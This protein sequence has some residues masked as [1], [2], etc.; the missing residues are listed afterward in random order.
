MQHST[1][2]IALKIGATL[3]FGL[4]YVGIKLAGSVPVGEVVLFRAFFALFPLFVLA[5]YTVGIGPMMRTERPLLHIVRSAVG[6][7][8][9]FLNFAALKVLPLADITAFGFVQPIFAVVLAAL[10]LKET[11]GPYRGAAVAIGFAGVMMM[12]EP[13]GGVLGIAAHGFS[14]GAGL[15]LGSALVS[16]FVVIYIRQ[17]SATEKSET[18]VFYFMS[19]C[20]VVGA[21]SLIW[22]RAPLSWG[23]AA[24]LA[25]AGVAGGFGQ[26]GMTFSYRYAE[27]SLLAPFDY[28]AM[29]W[30]VAFGLAIFG[31]VPA[32]LVL[33]GAAVVTAAGVFIA[34][35]EH[36]IGRELAS[37]VEAV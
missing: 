24:W 29:I 26:I 4:Q 34:W 15:A 6:A 10:V 3:A 8:G 12:I 33:I 32:L 19:L 14:A 31:E 25:A 20:T 28:S 21:V 35:R 23:A 27:P 36:R 2:G 17:M 18:I 1:R 16:A 30:A 5:H 7:T 22:W 9:M 13:H 37:R 11:V